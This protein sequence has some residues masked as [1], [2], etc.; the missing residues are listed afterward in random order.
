MIGGRQWRWVQPKFC[1][2]LLG[3]SRAAIQQSLECGVCG[4]CQGALTCWLLGWAGPWHRRQLAGTCKESNAA[5]MDWDVW[6]WWVDSRCTLAY[7]CNSS[8]LHSSIWCRFP[9]NLS[10]AILNCTLWKFLRRSRRWLKCLIPAYSTPKLSTRRQN[11]MGH[12]LWRQSP[13]VEA[14]L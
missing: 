5:W 4:G 14:A 11:W 2:P 8:N 10:P 1:C 3:P 9:Q 12:H 13:G 6:I 7:W